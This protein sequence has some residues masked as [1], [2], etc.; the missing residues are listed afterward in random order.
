MN[1]Y[2]F[3]V[4]SQIGHDHWP[5][6]AHYTCH[7]A[8]KVVT[9]VFVHCDQFDQFWQGCFVVHGCVNITSKHARKASQWNATQGFKGQ[10]ALWK[11]ARE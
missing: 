5:R 9:V 10:S 1:I 6:F 3:I 4:K 11:E 8:I 7:S 2:Y